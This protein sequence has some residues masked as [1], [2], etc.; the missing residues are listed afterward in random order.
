MRGEEGWLQMDEEVAAEEI[1]SWAAASSLV[2]N[3]YVHFGV[4]LHETGDVSARLS[5]N[6]NA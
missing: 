4:A 3:D 5:D 2:A 1:A 6:L